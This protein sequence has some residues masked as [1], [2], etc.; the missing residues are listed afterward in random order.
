LVALPLFPRLANE[1]CGCK[2]IDL[3]RLNFLQYFSSEKLNRT[4]YDLDSVKYRPDVL[5]SS[6][7]NTPDEPI[8]FVPFFE[9]K[10]GKVGSVLPGDAGDKSSSPNRL[11][12]LLRPIL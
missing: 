1:A 8:D 5:I 7:T 3:V 4:F 2:I 9:E 6:I 12:I 11:S 10:L